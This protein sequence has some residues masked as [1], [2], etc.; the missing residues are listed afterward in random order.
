MNLGVMRT[1]CSE[2]TPTAHFAVAADTYDWLQRP[3]SVEE[4][5]LM[6][7]RDTTFTSSCVPIASFWWLLDFHLYF[8]TKSHDDI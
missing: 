3:K 1:G 8:I 7:H 5:S 4:S 2:L 6:L